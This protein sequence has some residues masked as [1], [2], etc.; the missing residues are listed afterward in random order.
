MRVIKKYRGYPRHEAQ[1]GIPGPYGRLA[2]QFA[3]AGWTVDFNEDP[4]TALSIRKGRHA[5][6]IICGDG[7][8]DVWT[9]YGPEDGEP[10]AQFRGAKDLFGAITAIIG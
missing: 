2:G 8:S 3:D 7:N 10:I 5:F 4:E 6:G 1:A 9:V